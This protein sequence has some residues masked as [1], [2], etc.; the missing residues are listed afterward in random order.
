LRSAAVVAGALQ[1]DG[2]L[3]DRAR[4]RALVFTEVWQMVLQKPIALFLD[5]ALISQRL[6]PWSLQVADH[7]TILG[8]DRLISRSGRSPGW[9]RIGLAFPHT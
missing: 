9:L 4:I 5:M 7:Q 6:F 1:S 2:R 8:L 3:W